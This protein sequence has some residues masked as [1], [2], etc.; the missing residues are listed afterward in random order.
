MK[1]QRYAIVDIETTGGRASRDKITEIGIVLYDGQQIIDEYET[2][3]NPECYIPYGITQLTGI[4]QEMVE[5]AP[6]FCEVAKKIVEITEGAVFVAHNVRFDYSF[7]RAEFAR[8]GFTYT[9]KQLCTVRLSRKTFPGLSSYSLDSLTTYF[10]IPVSQRHRAMGDAMA[11]TILL[12]KI[13]HGEE[14]EKS[15][16]ELIN[17]GIKEALLP[18]NLSLEKIHALPEACGVYYFHNEKG[19]VVYVG[20]SINIKKRVAEHFAQ[21]TEK[22]RKL[23]QH[24]HEITYELTG[25]ELI[26]LLYESQE[27]KR[28]RPPINRAQ[29]QRNFPYV[30]H[31]FENE[32]GYLCFEVA[33]MT[34]KN[35][36]Q[37]RI[38][39]QYPKVTN[40]KSHLTSITEEYELCRKF[41]S[42]ESGGGACFHFHLKQ[43][44]GA[45]IRQESPESYN[46]R[47][48]QAQERL[49]T[50]F[51]KDFFLLDEGR[52]EEEHSIVLVE[53]GI[54]AGFGYIDLS[55][56]NGGLEELRDA[57]KP[58][59]G[60]PETTR[61]IQ[62]YMSKNP[63]LKQIKITV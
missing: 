26:A 33:K 43:C 16:A 2:L 47:A 29:R 1:A 46:E 15:V 44:Y 4:T 9:R 37:L 24:V 51:D 57:I 55:Q 59:P 41:T 49:S 22:A 23:Q 28:L 10:D 19:Q 56:I 53:D 11:T 30:I 40:A 38:V 34:A 12:Q 7:L 20:K 50:V 32:T 5:N 35:R 21:K 58:Y 48:N 13:L 39:S 3:I 18:K 61:I 36:K 45:C 60:N 8:L 63:K 17:L 25:S 14:S 6:K 54:F 52:S 27:I 42:L 31:S 62:R